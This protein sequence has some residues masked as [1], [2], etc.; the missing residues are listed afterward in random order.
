[1]I[2]FRVPYMPEGNQYADFFDTYTGDLATVG[3]WSQL[4][5][6]ACGYPATAPS[7][8]DY[9]TGCRYVGGP[10]TGNRTLLPDRCQLHGAAAIWTQEHRWRAEWA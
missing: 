3:D 6:L 2:G 8:G 7:V 1:M 9:L 10:S 5:P 4:Q